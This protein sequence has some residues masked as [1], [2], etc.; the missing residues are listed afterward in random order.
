ML[1][2]T[3]NV[4]LYDRYRVVHVSNNVNEDYPAREG[5]KK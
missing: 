5:E 3:L 2:L 1:L 4:I